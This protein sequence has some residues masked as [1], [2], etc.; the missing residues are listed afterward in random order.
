MKS[1]RTLPCSAALSY[2]ICA[3]LLLSCTEEESCEDGKCQPQNQTNPCTSAG[4][5]D[6]FV[7]CGS[8]CI[9]PLTNQDY[10]GADKYC[11]SFE[12]CGAG[13]TCSNGHCTGTQECLSF[14]D[15][16]IKHYAISNWD[17]NGDKC[18]T[19]DE[20]AKV[21]EIQNNAFENDDAVENLDDLNQFP[22]LK[23]IGSHAFDNCHNL[24]TAVLTNINTIDESAFAH[25]DNLSNVNLSQAVD[26]GNSSFFLCSA[27]TEIS[28]PKATNISDHAFGSCTNLKIINLSQAVDIGNSAFT[29][30][31]GLTE[32]NLPQ[33]VNIGEFAFMGCSILTKI[34]FPQAAS[35]GHASF[36][37]CHNLVEIN[38]PRAADI[39]EEAFQGCTSLAEIYL[40]KA[41]HF[42]PRAFSNT[43][44]SNLILPTPDPIVVEDTY[45][46]FS[47]QDLGIRS[48][49]EVTLTLN[50][51]KR[52]GGTSSP[53]VD[54]TG[55]KWLGKTWK[56]IKFVE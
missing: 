21:T 15:P 34:D 54:E 29:D 7:S 39:G 31:D 37:D 50:N 38:L 35:I 25:C 8:V 41:A 24:K 2:I 51:N 55:L 52:Y 27:L 11:E 22:N 13:Q 48:P 33:A 45:S 10:C 5:S 19:N 4:F 56:D 44:I 16:G 20:A 26:I 6:N 30:C 23:R 18:I 9:D 36:A 46:L 47:S 17:L 53:L 12:K 42:S 40:P 32:I 49:Q 14:N 43:S 3:I 28:L 1:T